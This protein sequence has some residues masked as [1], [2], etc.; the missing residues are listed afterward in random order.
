MKTRL[1]RFLIVMVTL[2]LVSYIPFF[3]IQ[4]ARLSSF[5]TSFLW[6]LP[7]FTYWLFISKVILP[8]PLTFKEKGLYAIL[9]AATAFV[10]VFLLNV[11]NL[12]GIPQTPNVIQGTLIYGGIELVILTLLAGLIKNRVL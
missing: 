7:L 11:T 3:Y 1:V 6:I 9:F 10:P 4:N 8:E 2:I 5:S 12:A